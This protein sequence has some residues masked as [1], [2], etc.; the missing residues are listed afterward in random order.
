MNQNVRFLICTG[1]F[2]CKA[3]VPVLTGQVRKVLVASG[4]VTFSM[5]KPWTA[6]RD[7]W[8]VGILFGK[9]SLFIFFIPEYLKSADNLPERVGLSG[10]SPKWSTLV[11]FP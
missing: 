11:S 6:T 7:L 3:R 5:V 10:E 2:H 1:E 8:P 4:K 9:V